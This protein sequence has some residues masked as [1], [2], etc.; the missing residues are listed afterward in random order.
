M[1]RRPRRLGLADDMIEQRPA[2]AHALVVAA[3]RHRDLAGIEHLAAGEQARRDKFIASLVER[4]P[5]FAGEVIGMNQRIKLFVADMLVGGEEPEP[6]T[7]AAHPVKARGERGRV[8]HG[9]GG[10]AKLSPARIASSV[11]A[12]SAGK[13]V[14]AYDPGWRRTLLGSKKLLKIR[15]RRW[16]PGYPSIFRRKVSGRKISPITTVADATITGYHRP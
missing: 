1:T 10:A 4:Q 3:H 16:I 6:P 14:R 11:T 9:R 5:G 13:M 7:L 15:P 2:G 12:I 8:C